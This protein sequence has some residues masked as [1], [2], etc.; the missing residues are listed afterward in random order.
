VADFFVRWSAAAEGTVRATTW[1]GYADLIRRFIVADLG[2]KLLVA[3][4]PDDIQRVYAACA[5]KGLAPGSIRRIHAVLHRALK[6]A[7]RWGYLP[8][9]VADAVD[10]PARTQRELVIPTAAELRRLLD[11]ARTAADPLA[12]LWLVAIHSGLRQG[13][14]LGLQWAD[15]DLGRAGLPA[16]IRLHDLRHASA[17]LML[18]GG[19]PLKVASARLGHSTIRVTADL[20][21]HVDAALDTDAAERLGRALQA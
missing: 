11:A 18:A 14:L 10:P 2:R 3:L 7:V 5:R 6:D 8:R 12:T 4:R 20:Y 21:Q 19:V 15:L 9:N 17:T 13:E 1:K 16:T